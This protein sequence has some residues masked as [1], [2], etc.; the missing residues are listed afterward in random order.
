MRIEV[1]ATGNVTEHDD[2]PVVQ[3]AAAELTAAAYCSNQSRTICTRYKA[4]QAN[5]RGRYR[6]SG[7][8]QRAGRGITGRVARFEITG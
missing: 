1:D 5:S 3:P 7:N 6:L 4:H 8:T 2:L